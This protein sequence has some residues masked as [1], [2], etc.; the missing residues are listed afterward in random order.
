MFPDDP[1]EIILNSGTAYEAVL[2]NPVH[3]LGIHI[4]AVCFVLD[5]PTTILENVKHLGST[6]INHRF[7]FI[8][9]RKEIDLRLDQ[10]QQ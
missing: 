3:G 6:F 2:G 10:V 5:E 9:R 8:D 7:M 4:E 1:V